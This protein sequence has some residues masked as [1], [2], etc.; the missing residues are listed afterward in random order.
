MA[1]LDP[2]F[3]VNLG[4]IIYYDDAGQD[5]RAGPLSLAADVWLAGHG[6]LSPPRGQL[7][8]QGRSR[9]LAQ[10][11]LADD[12][13]ALHARVHVSPGAGDFSRAGADGAVDLPHAAL[14]QGLADVARRRARLPHAERH[15]RR[16][17]ENHLGRRAEAVVPERPWP[18]PTR[19][20]ASC[21]VPRRWSAPTGT[22]SATITP[23]RAF[24]HEGR[25]LRSFL[26]GQPNTLVICGDRH[27]QYMSDRS[28]TKLR[29][30]SPAGRQRRARR[31]LASRAT[32]G[33]T[34]TVFCAW[35]A[36]SCRS[37]P[38]APTRAPR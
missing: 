33:P 17:R 22:T 3:F 1:K 25:E 7:L 34:F 4:D 21:S 15:A 11:L 20:F 23:T 30:Y 10:R 2:D 19:R 36:D 13:V 8:H 27:W 29:E 26:A 37:S 28:Q 31:R 16:S 5:G 18:P 35:P 24:A 38:S 6:G 12:A 14:R 32:I 9:H